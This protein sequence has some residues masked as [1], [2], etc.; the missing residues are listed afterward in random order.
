M[1]YLYRFLDQYNNIIYIG[2][3][4][5]LKKRLLQQHFT[6][7]GHLPKECYNQ[8]KYIEI[9]F[10]NNNNEA[11]M[12]EIFY[13]QKHLPFY[14]DKSSSGGRLSF[15]LPELEWSPYE[16][17]V[18]NSKNY[19]KKELEEKLHNVSE[20]I[21]T[22]VTYMQNILRG[23]N[24]VPWLDNLSQEEANQYLRVLYLTERFISNIQNISSDVD[25]FK[26][27]NESDYEQFV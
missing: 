24:E 2:K 25:S 19:S 6:K 4:T 26:S 23:M 18:V 15:D 7:N 3:T 11:T 14:N 27:H 13:I 9:A 16:P 21:N 12:Y 5:N 1:M 22:E 17:P 8:V 20:T 10:V